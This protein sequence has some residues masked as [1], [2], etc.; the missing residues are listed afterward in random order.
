MSV[1]VG[2]WSYCRGVVCVS[3]LVSVVCLFPFI[4]VFVVVT[5]EPVTVRSGKEREEMECTGAE[6]NGVAGV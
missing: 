5:V 6:L 3:V 1:S 2:V 4:F